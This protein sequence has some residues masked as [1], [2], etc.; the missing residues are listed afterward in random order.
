MVIVGLVI[1]Y[2]TSTASWARRRGT[3]RLP[4]TAR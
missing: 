1:G 3:D 4:S 2:E